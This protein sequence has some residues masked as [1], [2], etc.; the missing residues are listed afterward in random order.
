M[1]LSATVLLAVL[2]LTAAVPYHQTNDADMQLV[3]TPETVV[4]KSAHKNTLQ[5]IETQVHASESKDFE[6]KIH[7]DVSTQPAAT[8][9]ERIPGWVFFEGKHFMG[10]IHGNTFWRIKGELADDFP[11]EDFLNDPLVFTL[12][13]P[14]DFEGEFTGEFGNGQMKMNWTSG[15]T[16]TGR[17]GL[18]DH[19]IKG[20]TT[21]DYSP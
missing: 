7:V 5:T 18:S 17:S 4:D 12:N 16:I 9:A 15:A 21:I 1:H 10:R 11:V 8:M 20:K 2:Q 13:H 6:I 3:V 14:Q 19:T